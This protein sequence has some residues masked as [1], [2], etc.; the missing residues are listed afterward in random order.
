MEYLNILRA[1]RRSP[2]VSGPV[3]LLYPFANEACDRSQVAQICRDPQVDVLE[4][5]AVVMA[6][7]GQRRNW[8]VASIACPTLVNLLMALRAS[9]G[10]R[11]RDFCDALIASKNVTGLGISYLTKTLHFFRPSG[12]S[13]ILDQWTAKSMCALRPGVIR[14][15][16]DLPAPD[17]STD[18]YVMFCEMCEGLTREL[19][20]WKPAQIEQAL[21]DWKGGKWRAWVQEWF[22]S[23]HGSETGGPSNEGGTAG[24][25]CG[26]KPP[27]GPDAPDNNS[28]DVVGEIMAAHQS[29]IEVGMPLPPGILKNATAQV[30]V[31]GKGASYIKWYYQI[32][33]RKGR[34]DFEV[35]AIFADKAIDL[36]DAL[37]EANQDGRWFGSARAETTDR[38]ISLQMPGGGVAINASEVADTVVSAM[39]LLYV[40]VRCVAR[41]GGISHPML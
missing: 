14:M 11:D 6:W 1:H 18:E 21:F 16:G 29:A 36:R 23:V 2:S 15:R 30:W 22:A 10:F 33:G 3:E 40:Y 38:K 24:G 28:G 8:F 5:Y 4:A 9:G 37:I 20:G 41:N 27:Q 34:K 25:F 35:G 17:T 19:R 13:Y 31:G 39:S 26:Q 12:N 32:R 7:G